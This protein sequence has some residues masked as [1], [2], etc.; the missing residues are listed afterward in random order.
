[1]NKSLFI[2]SIILGLFT[3]IISYKMGNKFGNISC[4]NSADVLHSDTNDILSIYIPGDIAHVYFAYN[5]VY[6][7]NG[8]DPLEFTTR[9]AMYSYI[10]E[11]TAYASSTVG[12]QGD[13]DYNIRNGYIYA[14]TVYNEDEQY[15]DLVYDGPNW[16]VNAECD[17][18]YVISAFNHVEK[19]YDANNKTIWYEHYTVD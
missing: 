17:T 6:F 18:T 13:L 7:E 14:R 9:E 11:M 19:L 16:T 1:M 4:V 3:N 5:E 10:E 8:G 12:Y 15:T 2:A